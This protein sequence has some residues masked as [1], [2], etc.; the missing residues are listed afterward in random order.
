MVRI[1]ELEDNQDRE[2]G[3]GGAVG[4]AGWIFDQ[5]FSVIYFDEEQRLTKVR[6]QA[7]RQLPVIYLP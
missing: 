4:G 6:T 7:I 5:I 2:I 3:G 1:L